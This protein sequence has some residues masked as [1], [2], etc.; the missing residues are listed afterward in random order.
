[1]NNLPIVLTG[2]P[3]VGKTKVGR[4]LAQVLGVPHLDTDALVENTV[5]MPIAR[6]FSQLGEKRFREV[7]CQCILEA[8]TTPSVISL[9]GGSIETSAVREALREACVVWIDADEAEILR[10]VTRNEK[11]PLLRDNPKEALA[12][13][14]A[15]R[16]SY[17]DQLATIKVRSTGG[18]VDDVAFGIVK[19]L[20]N[21]DVVPVNE[22]PGYFVYIGTGATQFLSSF[23]PAEASQAVLI[24]DKNLV[25]APAAVAGA[26]E[27]QVAVHQLML[28]V[29]EEAK[30]IGVVQTAW[31]ALGQWEI[32]RRDMIIAVGGGATTDVAGF[33]AA[34]WLRGIYVCHCPTTLLGMVDASV[35][36]KTGINTKSG[37]NLIGSF[38]S[39]IGVV[40]DLDYL[41]TLGPRE[42]RAGLGEIIKCGLIDDREILALASANPRLADCDWA[43]S[44]G[45]S[46]LQEIITRAVQVKARVVS[47]DM[48]ED[49]LRE[50]LNYGHTLAHAIEKSSDYEVLHGE[51][52]AI[53]CVFAATLAEHL[54]VAEAGVAASTAQLFNQVG[55]PTG[56]GGDADEL[57]RYMASDKKRRG[58][59]LRFVLLKDASSPVTLPVQEQ[60]IKAALERFL[61]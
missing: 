39:P 7:E 40:A 61:S 43:V 12:A 5:G 31:D 19:R 51:A 38:Y 13:L 21:I 30:D 46:V 4:R 55:L 56:I 35:G 23:I 20:W 60:S 16:T 1:M 10:R 32:G 52:V 9:G 3:G 26:V 34:T 33:V 47:S 48:H 2:L 50:M 22:D 59:Q 54:G 11:R 27:Q 49:G 45:I 44:E 25:E 42:Y 28:P 36:G 6:I 14:S 8:L 29:G 15:R 18:P 17:Y 53:G 24:S 41:K 58:N 37:K 57:L